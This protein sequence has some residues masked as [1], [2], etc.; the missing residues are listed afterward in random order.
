[1]RKGKVFW[2]FFPGVNLLWNEAGHSTPSSDEVNNQGGK[3]CTFP[4]GLHG[5]Y[6][7]T[8]TLITKII[9]P[10]CLH[11]VVVGWGL[12]ASVTLRAM[13]AETYVPGRA[14]QAGQAL[15]EKSD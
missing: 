4:M 14:S 1:V 2:K 8:F 3:N 9:S 12:R 15:R 6:R 11:L 7:D 10:E 13:P 5:V